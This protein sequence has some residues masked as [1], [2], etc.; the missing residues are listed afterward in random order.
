[1]RKLQN[2]IYV[3]IHKT[4][5]LENNF[6]TKYKVACRVDISLQGRGQQT[7]RVHR[8]RSQLNVEVSQHQQG[9]QEDTWGPLG[10]GQPNREYE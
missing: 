2:T 9:T 8:V 3:L 4:A 6:H 1:M 7:T 5:N 10:G